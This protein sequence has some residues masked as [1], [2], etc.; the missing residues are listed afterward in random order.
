[1]FPSGT[2]TEME[3]SA[4]SGNTAVA[5]TVSQPIVQAVQS[6]TA[7]SQ[8]QVPTMLKS[9]HSLSLLLSH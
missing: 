1:M 7:A 8:G 9:Q 4:T 6:A 5:Q 2:M 3:F